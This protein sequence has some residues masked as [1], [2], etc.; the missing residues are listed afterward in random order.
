MPLSEEQKKN[1]GSLA[2]FAGAGALVGGFVHLGQY[3]ALGFL[4]T[5]ITQA[6]RAGEEF[7]PDGFHAIMG[8]VASAADTFYRQPLVATIVLVLGGAL[9]ALLWFKK[10]P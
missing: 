3:A 2:K 5:K 7:I 10:A 1:A 6:L 8:T 9:V 4:D